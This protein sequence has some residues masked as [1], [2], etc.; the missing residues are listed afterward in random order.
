MRIFISRALTTDSPIQQWLTTKSLSAYA[1]SLINIQALPTTSLPDADWHF[2]YSK[3][4]VRIYIENYLQK[5]NDKTVKYAAIGPQTGQY[6]L[7]QGLDC[8]FKGWGEAQPSLSSFLQVCQPS[9]SVLILRAQHSQN[10]FFELLTPYRTVIDLP[11]YD[12]QPILKELPTFDIG[13]FT[14]SLNV[15]AFFHKNPPPVHGCIAI[16]HPTFQTLL[17]VGLPKEKIKIADQPSEQGLL[18][19]L[20]AML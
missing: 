17:S 9:E 7:N 2:F 14:S 19:A 6:L 1:E 10:S 18:K 8:H 11:I 20:Q 4:G 15:K 3:S 12:N 16:G 13:I 5:Y